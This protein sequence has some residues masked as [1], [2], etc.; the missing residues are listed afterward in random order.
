VFA[1]PLFVISMLRDFNLIGMWSHAPWMNWFFLMLATP[2]Q[3]YTGKDYYI[4][5]YK[6]IRNRSA[7]MD[8]LIALGSSVAYL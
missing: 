5:G 4:G 6:S 8:V 2:V 3:F 7:N 1:L